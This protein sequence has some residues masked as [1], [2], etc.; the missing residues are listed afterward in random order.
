MEGEELEHS[1]DTGGSKDTP[2]QSYISP[3]ALASFPLDWRQFDERVSE[4]G[5]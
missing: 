4:R 1:L 5:V 3:K 2:L